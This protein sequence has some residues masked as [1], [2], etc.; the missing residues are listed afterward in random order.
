MTTP[1]HYV[2]QA[3]LGHTL[4]DS[5]VPDCIVIRFAR[6]LARTIKT[7]K[8]TSLTQAILINP[9]NVK[10]E[11]LLQYNRAVRDADRDLALILHGKAWRQNCYIEN[12]WHDIFLPEGSDLVLD[13]INQI[14]ATEPEKSPLSKGLDT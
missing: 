5:T 13:C 11:W 4:E 3:N 14:I 2:V 6:E 12:Y 8:V 7:I 1:P 10:T 9:D